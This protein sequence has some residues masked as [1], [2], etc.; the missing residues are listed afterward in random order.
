MPIRVF[1]YDDNIARRDSLKNLIQF[2]DEFEYA[3]EA[4]NCK[5]AVAEMEDTQPDVVLMDIN[6]PEVNGLEGLKKIKA[7]NPEI[8]VLMQTVFDDSDKIFTSIRNGA[9]GY[10]LKTDSSQK[11]LQAMLDVYNGG[12]VM[13]PGIA[14]KVLDYFKPS[15]SATTLS[16]RETEVLNLLANGLSYKMIADKLGVSFNTVSTYTKRIYEKLHVASLGEAISYYY[17]HLKYD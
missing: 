3:G 9:S 1:I 10:I 11:L 5:N 17:K 15:V 8:K 16:D 12:A 2:T 13:N 6:M 14:T 4:E 7:V